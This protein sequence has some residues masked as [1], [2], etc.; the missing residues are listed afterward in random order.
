M[1]LQ[2]AKNVI[3]LNVLRRY[4]SSIIHIIETSS[5]VVLYD[6]DPH[7][8]QWKKR[9]I[10]GTLFLYERSEEP[11]FGFYILNRVGL[12][13]LQVDVT[14]DLQ[15]QQVDDY[16]MYKNE[17]VHGIWIFGEEDRNRL[18]YLLEECVKKSV[19]AVVDYL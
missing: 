18:F 6:F 4:D 19:P 15:F 12:E 1:D 5:H 13:N 17:T 7:S 11:R 16:L 3:N 14:A 8:S 2:Q 9:G 10:E